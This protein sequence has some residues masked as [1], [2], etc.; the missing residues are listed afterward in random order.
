ML[1]IN[2]LVKEVQRNTWGW[3]NLWDPRQTE[4]TSFDP[5]FGVLDVA[6]SLK[7]SKLAICPMPPRQ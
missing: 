1:L 6:E 2:K 4:Q 7:K 3:L 5:R